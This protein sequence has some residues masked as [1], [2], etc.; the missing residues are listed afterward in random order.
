MNSS[1]KLLKRDVYSDIKV[2]MSIL[3]VLLIASLFSG[4]IYIFISYRIELNNK[5]YEELVR[6]S[7][8]TVVRSG[9]W[10]D[11]ERLCNISNPCIMN[12]LEYSRYDL[13]CG[14]EDPECSYG[15]YD[16]CKDEPVGGQI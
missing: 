10:P 8:K 13:G 16:W 15:H 11:G 1:L 4:V 3:G 2:C 12:C 7:K 9:Y 14:P 5:N 6:T